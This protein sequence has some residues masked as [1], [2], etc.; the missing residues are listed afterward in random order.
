MQISTIGRKTDL[1]YQP[2]EPYI[3]S[4]SEA[5]ITVY[6][7]GCYKGFGFEAEKEY[8]DQVAKAPPL[9]TNMG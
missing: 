7:V 4:L 5:G 8:M 1:D 3:K 9:P 6:H 2:S